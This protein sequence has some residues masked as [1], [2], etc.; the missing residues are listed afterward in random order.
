MTKRNWSYVVLIV[1]LCVSLGLNAW[2]FWRQG[3]GI[4]VKQVGQIIPSVP[5]MPVSLEAEPEA[6]KTRGEVRV[7]L[8]DSSMTGSFDEDG[9]Y[10]LDTIRVDFLNLSPDQK[11]A[12]ADVKVLPP[13]KALGKLELGEYEHWREKSPQARLFLYG[14]FDPDILYVIQ[15]P[16]GLKTT[17]DDVK[18]QFTKEPFSVMV[19]GRHPKPFLRFTEAGPY[20]PM[21]KGG[22]ILSWPMKVKV[23]NT[24]EVTVNLWKMDNQNLDIS[25]SRRFCLSRLAASKTFKTNVPPNL[26]QEISQVCQYYASLLYPKVCLNS[27]FKKV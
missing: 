1:V 12:L 4:L 27:S 18:H 11:I 15:L 21:P 8:Y 3:K 26:C 7:E 10:S 5:P 2:Q 19:K 13:P 25:D 20:Y 9:K 16:G 14:L 22:K 24:P 6:E 17:S 23:F